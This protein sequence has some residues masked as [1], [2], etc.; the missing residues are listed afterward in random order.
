M[1]L[2]PADWGLVGKAL[3]NYRASRIQTWL[4]NGQPAKP[5][6][7]AQLRHIENHARDQAQR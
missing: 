6:V 4:R 3:R 2:S 7:L 5:G 1:P